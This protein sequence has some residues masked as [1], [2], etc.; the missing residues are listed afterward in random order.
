[1]RTPVEGMPLAGACTQAAS[2]GKPSGSMA[3]RILP[4]CRSPPLDSASLRHAIERCQR[5][6]QSFE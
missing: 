3:V 6:T 1:M 2:A 5:N 4:I